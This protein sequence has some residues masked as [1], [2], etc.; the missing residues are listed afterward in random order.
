MEKIFALGIFLVVS[1][2][3]HTL[4]ANAL[5]LQHELILKEV[6]WLEGLKIGTQRMAFGLRFRT[7]L[8][9]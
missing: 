4:E 1:H 8:M 3:P 2:H 7:K 9:N 5:T 6:K